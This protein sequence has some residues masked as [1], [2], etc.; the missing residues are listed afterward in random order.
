MQILELVEISL[1]VQPVGRDDVGPA[2]RKFQKFIYVIQT[3]VSS[4]PLC[5]GRQSGR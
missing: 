1:Y 2:R 3:A 4:L 5:T